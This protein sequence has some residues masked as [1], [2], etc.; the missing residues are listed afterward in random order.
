MS[1][2]KALNRKRDNIL[3]QLTKLSSKPL[4]NLKE[5]ELRTVLDTLLEITEKFENIKQAY[6]EIDNDDE[7]KDVEP[8][9]NKIDEEFQVSGKLLLYKFTEANK[10]KEDNNSSENANNVQLPE[11]LLP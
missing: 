1:S 7:F 4:E 3:T 2:I 6:F 10:F 8:L 5:F 9:L 11:I